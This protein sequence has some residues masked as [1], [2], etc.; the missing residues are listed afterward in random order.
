VAGKSL[1]M[2]FISLGTGDDAEF[3][4][5]NIIC[6]VLWA[7]SRINI[8]IIIFPSCPDLCSGLHD[9]VNIYVAISPGVSMLTRALLIL[10]LLLLL[11]LSPVFLL[12]LL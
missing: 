1:L 10:P 2:L 6:G 7:I 12:F 11:L 9:I 4:G 3:V 8:L 5:W